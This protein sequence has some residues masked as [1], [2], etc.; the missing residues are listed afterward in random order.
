MG[1]RIVAHA[2]SRILGN[3]APWTLHEVLR[4]ERAL[5]MTRAAGSG[6]VAAS[7]NARWKYG[8]VAKNGL[9]H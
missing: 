8:G 9:L 1:G 2:V 7:A 4:T 3:V 5:C 6:A